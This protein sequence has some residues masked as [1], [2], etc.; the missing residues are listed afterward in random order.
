MK[1]SNNHIGSRTLD[2]LACS[3]VPQ[4]NAPHCTITTMAVEHATF[5]P[6]AQYLNKMLHTALQLHIF[7]YPYAARR[8]VIKTRVSCYTIPSVSHSTHPPNSKYFPTHFVFKHVNN[9]LRPE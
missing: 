5:W 1:H 6:V 9:S 3:A 4:Q 2:I 7:C 8:P